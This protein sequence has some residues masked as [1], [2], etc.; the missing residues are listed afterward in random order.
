MLT[1]TEQFLTDEIPNPAF[2]RDLIRQAMVGNINDA[3]TQIRYTPGT[4]TDEQ[5]AELRAAAGEL[6]TMI[7]KEFEL[8]RR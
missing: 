3:T 8:R 4:W 7:N 2:T 1:P 6:Y 5:L